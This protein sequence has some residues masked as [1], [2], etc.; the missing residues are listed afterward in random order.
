MRYRKT[1]LALTVGLSFSLA[2]RRPDS[3]SL[4]Q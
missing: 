2:A 4:L 1:R 3:T